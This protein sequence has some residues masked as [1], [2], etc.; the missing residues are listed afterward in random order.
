MTLSG[1]HSNEVGL[2][3]QKILQ[4]EDIKPKIEAKKTEI[5]KR[6]EQFGNNK[7]KELTEVMTKEK[8]ES[9]EKIMEEAVKNKNKLTELIKSLKETDTEVANLINKR[10]HK[11]SDLN[12]MDR[13]VNKYNE[14][15]KEMLSMDVLQDK[16]GVDHI[17]NKYSYSS[18]IPPFIEIKNLKF[19]QF[20][21][22]GL[23]ALFASFIHCGKKW[24]LFLKEERRQ[25]ILYFN[26]EGL[27]KSEVTIKV[28]LEIIHPQDKRKNYI[29]S[30]N[31][32]NIVTMP[33][34]KREYEKM[35]LEFSTLNLNEYSSVPG[36]IILE[37]NFRFQYD[38]FTS[39]I[40][41]L[42]GNK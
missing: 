2:A 30:T 33:D 23:N 38:F 26:I 6:I 17:L 5:N 9:E 11:E 31:S 36:R 22:P 18:L 27:K 40:P 13:L 14:L 35:P 37:T 29:S 41:E 21:K 32:F 12:D 16:K 3:Y 1:N 20:D 42:E 19:Q 39:F 24:R 28:S 4:I 8:K 25:F 10:Q 15:E 34:E 7:S